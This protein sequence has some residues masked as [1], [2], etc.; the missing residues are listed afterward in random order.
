LIKTSLS[1]IT[2][3]A[4]AL[5]SVAYAQRQPDSEKLMSAERDAMKALAFMDGIWRG[6]AWTILASGEKHNITQTERIGPMLD[7]AI[8]VL[9]GKG[10]NPDGKPGFNAFGIISFDP[11]KHAYTLHSYALGYAGDFSLT[12]TPDG[13]IWEIPAGPMTIRYKATVKDGDYVEVGDQIVKGKEPFRMFEM[14]L[15]RVSDTDW[16]AGNPVAP[17]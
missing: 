15:K 5:S 16:P 17:K 11:S 7:G 2:L 12:V 6:P 3:V 13:Y 4:L 9:E 8:K 1:I 10:Y 14:H